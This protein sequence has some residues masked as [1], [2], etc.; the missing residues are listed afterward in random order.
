M[1]PKAPK[2][3]VMKKI[4]LLTALVLP[5]VAFGAEEMVGYLGVFAKNLS[6]AMEVALDVEQGVL[7]ERVSEDSPAD[8]AGIKMGDIILEIDGNKIYNYG[9][10]KDIIRENPN[11]SV[12][13][14][15]YRQKKRITK[16]VVLAEREKKKFS[17]EFEV[18]DVEE[19]KE[20]W[21]HRKRDMNEQ[22][23]K[24]KEEIEELRE[25]L[26]EIKIRVK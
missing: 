11:N 25:E 6:E 22:I 14:V 18:P 26:E 12:D 10:L 24:L 15:L 9:V 16:K 23:E 8:K 17:F 2:E 13:I 7:V 1:E 4:L 20:V 3:V 21:V 19:L 5:L